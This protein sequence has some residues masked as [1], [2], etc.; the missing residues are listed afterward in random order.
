MD[1]VNR[2]SDE[3]LLHYAA[4]NR[5]FIVEI[6]QLDAADLNQ[7]HQEQLSK[8]VLVL[9]QYLVMLQ[10]NENMKAIEHMLAAKA[11]EH[12]LNKEKF[13]RDDV[14]GKTEKERRAWLLLNDPELKNLY[15]QVLVAEAEKMVISGMVKA[16]EGLL[17]ALK[18]ELS[19][20]YND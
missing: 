6:M 12:N 5:D 9:G 17:N 10:H 18:K 19:S 20:R 11:F 15:E 13:S 1:K 7:L 4:P 3:M 8:Y 14:Q 16:N 2:F